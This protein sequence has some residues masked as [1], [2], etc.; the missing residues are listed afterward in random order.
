MKIEIL[1][2]KSEGRS[3][4]YLAKATLRNYLDSLPPDFDSFHI[5]RDRATNIYLDRL[6]E[7]VINRRQIPTLVLIAESVNEIKNEATGLKILDGLQRTLRLKSIS[8]AV[9]IA[10]NSDVSAGR[11]KLLNQ[12]SKDL[13]KKGI[14]ASTFLR[15]AEEIQK[16]GIDFLDESL[17]QPQWFEIWSNLSEEE[18]VRKMLL[19]NAG[20]KPVKTRHQLE[21]L[22]LG[23]LPKLEE[24][25]KR[26]FTVVREKET[27]SISF[28]KN[29]KVGEYHFA[30][31]VA[32]LIAYYLGHPVTTNAELISNIQDDES[33]AS[34][35]KG[36]ED[37]S[38]KFAASLIDF[39]V[40]LDS[41]ISKMEGQTG[42]QWLGRE[43]ILIGIFAALGEYA[44]KNKL[45]PEKAFK[46]LLAKVAHTEL[47]LKDFEK[48]RNQQDL[49]KVNIGTTNKRAIFQ[50]TQ[51]ILGSG[52]SVSLDWRKYFGA[53]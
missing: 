20:H 34:L 6:F 41:L 10:R 11:S 9:E 42:I 51:E 46:E 53:A 13:N 7:T 48:E 45:Q 8:E 52:H 28:T 38:Y 3:T 36:V 15:V 25:K 5:Q 43:V 49:S 32:S 1:D 29:R 23:L 19:L 40:D 33:E 44:R 16:K 50:A 2:S 26:G 24:N 17:S 27:S 37:F 31:I 18:Q 30:A 21:L 12:F 4:C 14:E 39:L 35:R 22:F 47:N